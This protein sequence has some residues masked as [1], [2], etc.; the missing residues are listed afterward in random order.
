VIVQSAATA[1]RYDGAM[2]VRDVLMG[3]GF[4]VVGVFALL[5]GVLRPSWIW[6]STKF[7]GIRDNL[8]DGVTS[9][10]F[11]GFGVVLCVVGVITLAKRD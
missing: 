11:L 8:G 4:A 2:S 6:E 5:N 1:V 9:A 7:R 3:V 10:I